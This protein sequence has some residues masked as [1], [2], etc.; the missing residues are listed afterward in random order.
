MTNFVK[1]SFFLEIKSTIV[2]FCIF[3][4][5]IMPIY[6]L[7]NQF[8]NQT[9]IICDVDRKKYCELKKYPFVTREVLNIEV[10]YLLTR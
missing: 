1:I 4:F 3:F 6:F 5:F 10:E 8:N 9:I 7:G 2:R